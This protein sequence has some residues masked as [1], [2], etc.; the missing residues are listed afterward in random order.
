MYILIRSHDQHSFSVGKHMAAAGERRHHAVLLGG[1]D[2]D[3]VLFPHFQI[4]RRPA[5][6]VLGHADL[7]DGVIVGQGHIVKDAV[8]AVGDGGPVCH[9][10]F[11]IHHVVRA[12]SQEKFGMAVLRG[13]GEDESGA[14]VLQQCGGFQ[15]TLNMWIN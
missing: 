15:R 12:V 11:Q 10:F 2:V 8:V 5:Y 7:I 14:V 9:L 13:P 3:I 1:Q 4:N 6:P